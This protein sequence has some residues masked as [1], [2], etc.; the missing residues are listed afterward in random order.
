M[1][2]SIFDAVK[3]ISVSFG[4][5]FLIFLMGLI[6]SNFLSNLAYKFIRK[7]KIPIKKLIKTTNEPEDIIKKFVK[8]IIITIFTIMS[9]IQIGIAVSLMKFLLYIFL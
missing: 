4:L 7:I 3:Y 2:I 1:E 5:A 6:L 9:L 8:T